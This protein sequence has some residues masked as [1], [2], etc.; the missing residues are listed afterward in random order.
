MA[1]FGYT[2]VTP[3]EKTH[4]V[5]D[6]FDSVAQRY[7]LMNDLMSGGLHRFWKQA[8][9][10][11]A[12]LRPGYRVLDLAGGTGDLANWMRPMLGDDGQVVLCDI[13]ASMLA[14]GRDRMLDSG[15]V[16]VPFVQG[17]ASELPFPNASFDRVLIAFG[18]RNV[19]EPSRCLREMHRVL[20]P[21]GWA[22]V[23][24]F[25]KPESWLA[26]WY[27]AYRHLALP[28]LGQVI[29]NDSASYHYLAESIDR[30]PDQRS[31]REMMRAAGFY[32]CQYANMSAGIVAIHRGARVTPTI[33]Q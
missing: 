5:G 17:D 6:V 28:L 12:R 19:T 7:D 3:E 9:V 8:L 27:H 15:I 26:P 10:L 13:N 16:D 14:R 29:A 11:Q 4:L 32:A 2:E 31:M 25:S 1:H 20:R 22:L 21:G 30:H 24:E 23:L 33:Q 18:L